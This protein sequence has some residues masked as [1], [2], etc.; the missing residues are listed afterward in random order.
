MKINKVLFLL[1]LPLLLEVLVACCTC[2]TPVYFNYTNCNMVIK[3]L[4][5]SEIEPVVTESNSIAKQAFGLR[6][7]ISRNED[8]CKLTPSRSVFFQS[9]YATSCECPPEFEYHA[10]DSITDIK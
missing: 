1:M 2:E 6:I 4:D 5:N 3:N 10:L 7:E 9:A 8:I